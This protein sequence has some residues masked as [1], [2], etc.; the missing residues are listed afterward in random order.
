M[1][2]LPLFSQAQLFTIDPP[3]LRP[4]QSRAIQRLRDRVREGKRRILLVAPTGA[5]KTTIIAS[6]I[7]TSSV[8][9]LMV[10][11]ALELI[12]QCVNEL[13][14]VGITNV[15]VIRSDDNR[16]NPNATVQVA[17][18]QTLRRR[19]L[20]AQ[21]GLILV[22]EAHLSAAASYDILFEQNTII[23]GF[24]ATPT[25]FDG[26]PLGNRFDCL[27]V[28]ATYSDLLK[29]GFIVEPLCYS[30]PDELDLSTIKTIAGD[31]NEEQ[32]GE[33]MR[34][35]KLVGSLLEHWQKLANLHPRQGGHPGL[36]EGEYR[37]TFIFA[38][39]IQHSLDICTRFG[40]AGVRI[41]HLD[42]TTSETER[43]RITT[44][45][46]SGELDA[47]T[48]VGVLL[49]GVDIPSA[50]CVVHARPTQSMVLWRQSSGRILR[51]WHPNCRRGCTAH[52]SV[53]P[54]LIDH[55]GNIQRL[56]FPHEDVHWELTTGA[57]HSE[58]KEATRI[59]KGC[60][61]YLKAWQRLCPYCGTDSP[62]A[63]PTDLPP[64]TEEKLRQ[65]ATTPEAMRR[66]YFETVM[67]VA[68]AKG[69]KPGF[70]G[71]RYKDRYGCW[72][73]W[74]WSEMAK[75]TF[76]SDPLWQETFAANQKRKKDRE[77]EKM[78]KE[79]AKIEEPEKDDDIEF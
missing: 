69:Y 60:F 6:I 36:E 76:A 35:S 27:E 9:V 58:R 18:I 53:V 72:P 51:P 11:D 62:P 78:A 75:A 4:Y 2:T 31:Y 15:G 43:R 49:K 12:D 54:M 59:C 61:A 46:G 13:A 22:D 56:G 14:A 26:K 19:G 55:A 32:L 74:E 45:L 42:G 63:D 40:A 1:S 5:G 38:V 73:P 3:K 29:G 41:A 77:L 47:I 48:N 71:A 57:A 20:A 23:L 33:F 70:A 66:M 65:L 67:K 28:V 52:P 7:R 21:F 68:R 10:C 30:G 34:D 16:T 24:T 50:K 25:R 39:N 44:A 79:L 37:R 64:E 8:S 17:S